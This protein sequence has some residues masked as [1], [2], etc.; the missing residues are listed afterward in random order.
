MNSNENMN[1]E[2]QEFSLEIFNVSQESD[3]IEIKLDEN[4]EVHP[5]DVGRRC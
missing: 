1:A 4:F 5:S 3:D 2:V